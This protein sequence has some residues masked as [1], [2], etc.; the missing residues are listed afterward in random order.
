MQT[1]NRVF[2]SSSPSLD[3]PGVAAAQDPVEFH[4]GG[5]RRLPGR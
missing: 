1:R 5:G 2:A 3:P 4:I